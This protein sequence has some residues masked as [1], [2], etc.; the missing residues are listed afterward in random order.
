MPWIDYFGIKLLVTS[1]KKM[2]SMRQF[3][4]LIH[5]TVSWNSNIRVTT[6]WTSILQKNSHKFTTL[7]KA[8]HVYYYVA[9]MHNQTFS[10]IKSLLNCFYIIRKYWCNLIDEFYDANIWIINNHNRT[11]NSISYNSLEC[12]N[13]LKK[14]WN[15]EWLLLSIRYQNWFKKS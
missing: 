14:D 12:F 8:E 7:N 5:E 9:Y 13:H 11:L 6:L 10:I 2:K 4:C 15:A 3:C 1:H